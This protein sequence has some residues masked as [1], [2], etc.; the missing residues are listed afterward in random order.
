MA[1]NRLYLVDEN[2]DSIMV[3]KSFGGGWDWRKSENEITEW[4]SNRDAGASFGNPHEMVGT[5]LRLVTE[6]DMPNPTVDGGGTL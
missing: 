2:G 4:L 5:K 1:N 3:A 6:Y